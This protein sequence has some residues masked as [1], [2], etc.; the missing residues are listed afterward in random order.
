MN[1]PPVQA[2]CWGYS[3]EKGRSEWQNYVTKIKVFV[4]L[5]YVIVR[6]KTLTMTFKICVSNDCTKTT[7]FIFSSSTPDWL[8]QQK[9]AF[10]GKK[11]KKEALLALFKMLL[12]CQS[13]YLSCITAKTASRKKCIKEGEGHWKGSLFLFNCIHLNSH[14][15]YF[16]W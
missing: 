7:E 5:C 11:K 14:D 9:M 15:F 16:D 8:K 2:G 3:G 12:C 4:L 10:W 1:S 6:V 13:I